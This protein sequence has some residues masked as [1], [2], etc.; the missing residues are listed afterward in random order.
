MKILV[1]AFLL[2]KQG[3]KIH[4]G[5]V[6]ETT[7][8][9]P[10]VLP[11]DGSAI[12]LSNICFHRLIFYFVKFYLKMLWILIRSDSSFPIKKLHLI[13]FEKKSVMAMPYLLHLQNHRNPFLFFK[14]FTFV[15]N[16]EF[17]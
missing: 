4:F 1:P 5:N 16:K 14:G 7:E 9:V 2:L 10:A 12:F 3:S 17:P 15:N 6:S 13:G 11:V 8:F